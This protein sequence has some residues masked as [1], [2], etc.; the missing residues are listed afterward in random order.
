MLLKKIFLSIIFSQLL[1]LWVFWLSENEYLVVESEKNLCGVF[2]VWTAKYPNWLWDWWT[3]VFLQDI[4]YT[5]FLSHLSCETWSIWDC[6]KKLWYKYA[7]VAIWN[8]YI[9]WERSWAEFLASQDIIQVRSLNPHEY[10]LSEK[11]TRKEVMKIVINTS[12]S[13]LRE[14]CRGVFVDVIHD[15][16]CKY[17]E[18]ALDNGYITGNQWFR[19]NENLTKSEA[20]KLIFKSRWIE[21]RYETNNWQEDYISTAYYLGYIDKKFSDYN[22]AAT[23]WWMFEVIAKTF[24]SFSN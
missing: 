5:E 18:T 9:S 17:I 3:A 20:L 22:L 10:K 16:G 7:G 2:E 6:C 14:K 11:I 15:W 24:P 19:P 1:F 21:K 8:T 12:D 23:R 13:E 4:L